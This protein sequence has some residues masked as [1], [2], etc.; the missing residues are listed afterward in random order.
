MDIKEFNTKSEAEQIEILNNRLKDMKKQGLKID[1]FSKGCEIDFSWPSQKIKKYGYW[2]DKSE[3]VLK[4]YARDGEI[5][6]NKSDYEKLKAGKV[7]TPD[8]SESEKM[9]TRLQKEN[10]A[11]KKQNEKLKNEDN[12]AQLISS[13]IDDDTTAYYV[14][15]PKKLIPIWNEFVSKQ[16][17][18]KQHT[19]EIALMKFVKQNEEH[20]LSIDK[21]NE[22]ADSEIEYHTI[23][24]CIC[25][26]ILIEW[27]KYCKTKAKVI[28]INILTTMALMKMMQITVE[29]LK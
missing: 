9:I 3:Y 29:E 26:K 11:L 25:K 5:V 1:N 20:V 23:S 27:R 13:L 19:F 21:L 10:D 7:I 17:Y 16:V 14:K 18:G 12:E 4:R 8:N 2:L 15:V 22:L 24:I 28:S 6:V